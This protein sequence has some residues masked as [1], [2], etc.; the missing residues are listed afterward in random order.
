MA[1]VAA[2]PELAPSVWIDTS[3]ALE[4]L[5]SGP[6]AKVLEPPE[7]VAEVVGELEGARTIR[8]LSTRR[9]RR[10]VACPLYLWLTA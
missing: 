6:H 3:V 1:V 4:I 9:R 7:L 2:S 10:G 8:T 5:E